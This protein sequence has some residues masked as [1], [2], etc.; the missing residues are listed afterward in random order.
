MRKLTLTVVLILAITGL[1]ATAQADTASRI[2]HQ[3][4][5]PCVTTSAQ[6]VA[7]Q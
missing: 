1:T 5:E 4:R 7:W 2:T 3:H 6:T